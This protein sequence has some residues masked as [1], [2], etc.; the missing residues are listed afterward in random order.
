MTH[1]LVSQA[2]AQVAQGR[3]IL[4][5]TREF[6]APREQVYAALTDPDMLAG[7]WGPEGMSA[8][9]VDL[10][11]RVGGTY[12][13][14]MQGGEGEIR[15]LSG[16]YLEIEPPSRLSFT[17][18]WGRGADKSPTTLVTLDFIARGEGTELNLVHK[19]FE[20]AEAADAHT[21]GWS[22]SFVCL[23]QLIEGG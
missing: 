20:G 4:N 19:G 11:L 21:M 22:S 12:A 14:D 6:A 15:H 23:S 18:Q 7:W 2:A 5:L 1:D 10:D 17:W 9:R 3:H 13:I 16:T 8:P